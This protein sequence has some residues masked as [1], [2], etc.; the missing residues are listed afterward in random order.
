M[1]ISD[2]LGLSGLKNFSEFKD[3]VAVFQCKDK[4]GIELLRAMERE[5]EHLRSPVAGEGLLTLEALLKRYRSDTERDLQPNTIT[6]RSLSFSVL[7]AWLLRMRAVEIRSHHINTVV[8]S[9]ADAKSPT[10]ANRLL[11]DLTA[12][13]A[14]GVRL[15]FLT[16][17]PSQAVRRLK[18]DK[19]EI[20][21]WTP[22]DTMK[23]LYGIRESH[24]YTFF[25]LA[26]VTGMRRGELL[27]LEWKHVYLDAPEPYLRVERMLTPEGKGL[28]VKDILKT[29]RS[30]RTIV[31]SQDA[32]D[33]LRSINNGLNKLVIYNRATGTY[34]NPRTPG[35]MLAKYC[36]RL[37]LP[38]V[39]V[40]GLRHTHASHLIYRGVPAQVVSDRLGHT[41]T[42]TTLNTYAHFFDAQRSV[43]ALSDAE[44]FGKYLST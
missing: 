36:L 16:R 26:L 43:A 19:A 30:R 42:T 40:H 28:V 9:V 15:E 38:N 37:G 29:T 23:F 21:V 2:S 32:V 33:Y 22:A 39:S 14:F 4:K 7:P 35:V 17:N 6:I 34:Y 25:Y 44:L 20:L 12:V 41:N 10:F 11:S 8:Q 1:F 31:L 18:V 13:F 27:A 5:A 3:F 24:L